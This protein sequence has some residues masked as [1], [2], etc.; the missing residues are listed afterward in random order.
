MDKIVP[1]A[2][3]DATDE[4]IDLARTIVMYEAMRTTLDNDFAPIHNEYL[5]ARAEI[6][7]KIDEL[8]V[9]LGRAFGLPESELVG[10]RPTPE[11]IP[12]FLDREKPRGRRKQARRERENLVRLQERRAIAAQSTNAESDTALPVPLPHDGG[13]RPDR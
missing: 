9:A 11:T 10:F 4:Q 3:A 2:M 7:A 12:A 8:T 1:G 13:D 5:A 6:S